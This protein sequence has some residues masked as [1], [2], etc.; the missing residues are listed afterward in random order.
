MQPSLYLFYK[1]WVMR[2]NI[3]QY[4]LYLSQ[5]PI[6]YT[7]WC[8]IRKYTDPRFAKKKMKKNWEERETHGKKIRGCNN[9]MHLVKLSSLYLKAVLYPIIKLKNH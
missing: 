7:S 3:Q 8:F 1:S 9:Y 5:Q 2:C 6:Q 4:I